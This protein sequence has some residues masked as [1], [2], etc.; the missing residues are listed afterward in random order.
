M[1]LAGLA[2]PSGKRRRQRLPARAPPVSTWASRVVL[3]AAASRSPHP[4]GAQR[5]RSFPDMR[6]SWRYLS[7]ATSRESIE[8]RACPIRPCERRTLTTPASKHYVLRQRV[9]EQDVDNAP[10]APTQCC[11]KGECTMNWTLELVVVPVSDVDRAKSFYMDRLGFRLE[12]DRRMS[13]T[14]RVVQLTPPGSACSIALLD[15]PGPAE[16]EP[17]SL[18]GLQLVVNDLHARTGSARRARGRGQRS[19]GVRSGWASAWP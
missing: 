11:A 3:R 2:T 7:P 6:R 1:Q 9:L 4:A 10:A 5:I 17:G 13:D 15:R 8:P 19:P 12:V 16:S 14:F 18:K